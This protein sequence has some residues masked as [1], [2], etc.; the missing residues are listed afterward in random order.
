LIQ[1][2]SHIVTNDAR[3]GPSGFGL[4]PESW[5]SRGRRF[6]G[7]ISLSFSFRAL[8]EDGMKV[9]I[10]QLLIEAKGTDMDNKFGEGRRQAFAQLFC[11]DQHLHLEDCLVVPANGNAAPR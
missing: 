3:S 11:C 2:Y 7:L 8:Q 5:W 9:F 6:A 4:C 1:D 10:V